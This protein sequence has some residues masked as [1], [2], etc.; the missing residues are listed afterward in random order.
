MSKISNVLQISLVILGLARALHI[1]FSGKIEKFALSPLP[2]VFSQ[3]YFFIP[4]KLEIEMASG[5]K[6]QWP[7]DNQLPFLKS[8]VLPARPLYVALTRPQIFP[9]PAWQKI[10]DSHLCN[11]SVKKVVLSHEQKSYEWRCP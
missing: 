2:Q 1:P 6:R 4:L 7:I 3:D 10:I 8:L 9:L 11:I 5:E